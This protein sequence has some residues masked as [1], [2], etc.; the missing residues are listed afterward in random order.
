MSTFDL[1]RCSNL[2]TLETCVLTFLYQDNLYIM[3]RP[4]CTIYVDCKAD[5][6]VVD[7]LH[8]AYFFYTMWPKMCV[9]QV[10]IEP[11]THPVLSPTCSQKWEMPTTIQP[12]LNS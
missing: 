4:T 10:G 11:I 8:S 5:F 3:Y 6:N 12:N 9:E 1:H 2:I 7:Q